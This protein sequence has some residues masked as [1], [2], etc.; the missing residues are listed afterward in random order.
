M[1]ASGEFR[2]CQDKAA[3]AGREQAKDLDH[4]SGLECVNSSLN[5]PAQFSAG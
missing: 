3:A 1:E 5:L 2:W 4:N